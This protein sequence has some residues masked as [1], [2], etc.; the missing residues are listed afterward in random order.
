[1]DKSTTPTIFAKATPAPSSQQVRAQSIEPAK[2]LSSEQI[3]KLMDSVT[4]QDRQHKPYVS[5][6]MQRG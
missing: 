5:A 1:M 3:S 6:Y 2:P 4:E